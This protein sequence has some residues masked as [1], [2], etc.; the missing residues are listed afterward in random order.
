MGGLTGLTLEAFIILF[1]VSLM[2]GAAAGAF[3]AVSRV[4]RSA[5]KKR[6]KKGIN[7]HE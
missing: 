4:L 5:L 6:L 3:L 2:L 1:F 7:K